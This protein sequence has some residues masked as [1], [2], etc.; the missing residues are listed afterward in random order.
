MIN[1]LTTKESAFQV[2]GQLLGFIIK[3]GYKLKYLRIAIGNREYW[4]KIPKELRHSLDPAIKPGCWLEIT[5]MGRVK[6]KN[7]KLDLK[8]ESVNLTSP[9]ALKETSKMSGQP[10]QGKI[11]ICQKS[12]CW[13][14]GGKMICEKLQQGLSDRGLGESVSIQKTGCLKKCKH[15]PNLV[16]LPERATYQRFHPQDVESLLE[17]HFGT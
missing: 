2:V 8:A 3:D 5:G 16:V 13:K 7:G 14:R 6:A 15:A 10:K 12:D 4:F 1:Q 9:E 17:K 11:L